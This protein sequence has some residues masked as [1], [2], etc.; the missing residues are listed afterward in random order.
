MIIINIGV[1]VYD[2]FDYYFLVAKLL[3][4]KIDLITTFQN[5]LEAINLEFFTVLL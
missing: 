3:H 5:S 2:F 1:G 4:T